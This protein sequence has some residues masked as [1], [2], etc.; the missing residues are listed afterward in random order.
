M[1][2]V[3]CLRRLAAVTALGAIG[4]LAAPWAG[5]ERSPASRGDHGAEQP[6]LEERCQET[7][8]WLQRQLGDAYQVRVH[9]P[10]VVAGDGS[11][12]DLEKWFAEALAPAADAMQR[13]Y[14]RTAPDEPIS[15]IRFGSEDAYRVTAQK[16]FGEAPP[17]PYGYYRPHLRIVLL[18]TTQRGD[19]VMRHEITHALMDF[20]FPMAPAW[21]R[22]GLASLHEDAEG[23]R[24]SE[25]GSRKWWG[26]GSNP[27]WP[28]LKRAL[29]A[30][31]MPSLASLLE[32]SSLQGEQE[33]LRYA[34]AQYFCRFLQQQ[35]LLETF[36]TRLRSAGTSDPTGRA[37]LMALVPG[38][39]WPEWESSFRE[40]L[41]R[42]DPNRP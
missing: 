11:P 31:Q 20:D 32:L 24:K 41:N 18:C 22:E 39:S 38:R 5:C 35:R 27:R 40:Y 8:A 23:I 15:V 33:S 21:L 7:A 17:S 4:A 3:A 28:V 25:V 14:F 12:E 19:V 34:Q 13:R 26:D 30:G 42:S 9:A 37:T 6:P 16:L 36:Y 1:N 2:R 29:D 10:W